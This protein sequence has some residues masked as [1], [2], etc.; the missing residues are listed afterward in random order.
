MGRQAN[1]GSVQIVV[2][3]PTTKTWAEVTN[4]QV[5]MRGQTITGKADLDF[6]PTAKKIVGQDPQIV[7]T[8]EDDKNIETIPVGTVGTFSA[9]HRDAMLASGVPG[10]AHAT[11]T[12]INAQVVDASFGGQHAQFSSV[13]HTI[14][15]YSADGTTSPLTLAVA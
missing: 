7:I 15:L 2:A 1:W 10:T 13:S 8:S 9:V 14:E 12:C 11:L 6:Y 3:G 4:I 5:Q